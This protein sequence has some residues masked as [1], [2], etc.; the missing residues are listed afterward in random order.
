[1]RKK[2][3]I[4]QQQNIMMI[5]KMRMIVA[6]KTMVKRMIKKKMKK[7]TKRMMTMRVSS[8]RLL[9][10]KEFKVRINLNN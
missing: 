4:I 6:V 5:R 1:M 7:K 3:I 10:Q 9:L 2:R 8:K